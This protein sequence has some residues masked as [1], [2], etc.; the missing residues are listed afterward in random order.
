[1]QSVSF[2]EE[3]GGVDLLDDLPTVRDFTQSCRKILID[4]A[5][6][7][8]LVIQTLLQV[9]VTVSTISKSIKQFHNVVIV[10]FAK[11]LD[12][13]IIKKLH[14]DNMVAVSDMYIVVTY[15]SGLFF[16]MAISYFVLSLKGTYVWFYFVET[17]L[18]PIITLSI[19]LQVGAH[20]KLIGPPYLKNKYMTV[21]LWISN[22]ILIYFIMVSFL[23]V[24]IHHMQSEDLQETEEMRNLDFIH[25]LALM[26]IPMNLSLVTWKA[27]SVNTKNINYAHTVKNMLILNVLG[28]CM[29]PLIGFII[30]FRSQTG[31]AYPLLYLL[32]LFT[33]FNSV[34]ALLVYMYCETM[35]ANNFHFLSV[36]EVKELGDDDVC[37]V[38]LTKHSTDSC[39]LAC[40]HLTHGSCL[41]SM[42]RVN[43][44]L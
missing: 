8:L 33:W 36:A 5:N 13:V 34:S 41:V 2:M 15:L 44:C 12:F 3:S 30:C 11:V 1:M 18:V 29:S 38:C 40:G 22:S 35:I 16:S 31:I 4:I 43:V 37:P 6:I 10:Q 20:R 14:L 9:L 17:L 7:I 42:M 25:L 23:N 27:I 24:H 19:P 26:E 32:R 21:T 28:Q 39:R